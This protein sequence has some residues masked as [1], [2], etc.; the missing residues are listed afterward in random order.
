VLNPNYAE[1]YY[2]RGVARRALG[3][4]QGAVAEYNQAL[5][6]NPNYAEAYYNRGETSSELET[7]RVQFKIFRKQQTY[8]RS[9]EIKITMKKPLTF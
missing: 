3:D 7:S 4:K 2:N 8:F 6:I 5:R 9:K 1:A